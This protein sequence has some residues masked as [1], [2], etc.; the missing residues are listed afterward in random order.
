MRC[1]YIKKFY[2]KIHSVFKYIQL[3]SAKNL[4]E[5]CDLSCYLQ[6]AFERREITFRSSSVWLV[7]VNVLKKIASLWKLKLYNCDLNIMPDST[8]GFLYVCYKM[9]VFSNKSINKK[10]RIDSFRSWFMENG[11]GFGCFFGF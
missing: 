4:K 2:W 6:H 9:Y 7:S 8:F 5:L 10:L 11:I 3:L 1:N